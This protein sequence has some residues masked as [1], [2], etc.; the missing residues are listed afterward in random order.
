M[1]APSPSQSPTDF[2]TH[3]IEPD[4]GGLTL[5]LMDLQAAVA[6]LCKKDAPE[7]AIT[8][9]TVQRHARRTYD[10]AVR[11]LDGLTVADDT[12]RYLES[13]LALGKMRLLLVGEKF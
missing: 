7:D 10:E 4:S 13:Q 6:Y 9:A 12:R 3:L 8:F 11:V 2:G 1:R 5:L